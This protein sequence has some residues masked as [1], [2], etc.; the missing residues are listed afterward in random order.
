LTYQPPGVGDLWLHGSDGAA[1]ADLLGRRRAAL[2]K[3]L[4]R[5]A[6][7]RALAERTG[8]SPGGVNTHLTVLRRTGLVARRREGREVLYVRTAAGSALAVH[9]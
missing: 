4:D 8:W 3:S 5:P 1:L 6:S 2:L 7:T 9:A